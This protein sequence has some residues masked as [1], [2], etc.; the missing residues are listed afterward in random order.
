MSAESKAQNEVT[1]LASEIKAQNDKRIRI[2]CFRDSYAI[3]P[4]SAKTFDFKTESDARLLANALIKLSNDDSL[5]RIMWFHFAGNFMNTGGKYSGWSLKFKYFV[6][7]L[8]KDISLY[9]SLI[10]FE[11]LVIVDK[12]TY[13]CICKLITYN[14]VIEFYSFPH[15]DNL[16]S[17]RSSSFYSINIPKGC[18]Y[19]LLRDAIKGTSALKSIALGENFNQ[20]L[21]DCLKESIEYNWSLTSITSPK[22]EYNCLVEIPFCDDFY[23]KHTLGDLWKKCKKR[24]ENISKYNE[25]LL[26]EKDNIHDKWN[27]NLCKYESA[28]YVLDNIL[29]INNNQFDNKGNMCYCR[30]CHKERNDKDTYCRGKPPSRYEIPIGWVRFGIKVNQEFVKK[31]D[32]FKIWHVSYHGT[33]QETLK[34]IFDSGCKLLLP[35]DIKSDGKKLEIRGGHIQQSFRRMNEYTKVFELFD[36]QQIYTSPTIKYSALNAYAQ[37]KIIGDPRDRNKFLN[38]QY[39]FQCRQKPGSYLVGHETCG[40]KIKG[41]TYSKHFNNNQVEWYTKK[42]KIL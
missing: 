34:P 30:K 21:I 42:K 29:D 7:E 13:Q 25:S 16:F 23:T 6:D 37:K 4:P 9:K 41:V 31:H 27:D 10:T 12:L 22:S 1:Q 2:D 40:A 32:V 14:K 24:N 28:K 19:K 5:N 35:G 11:N 15:Y 17:G 3:L 36:P 33:K 39:V 38:V 8:C 18:D 26:D 20:L